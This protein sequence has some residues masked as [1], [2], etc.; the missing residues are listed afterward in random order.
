MNQF[1]QKGFVAERS[2]RHTHGLAG[3]VG[4]VSS[5]IKD[6]TDARA[7]AVLRIVRE[8]VLE[9]FDQDGYSNSDEFN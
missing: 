3:S 5:Y 7:E 1:S 8:R 9:I 2:V 6:G 4:W